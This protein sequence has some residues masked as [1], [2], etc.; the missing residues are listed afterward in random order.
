MNNQ[1]IQFNKGDVTQ[2]HRIIINDD[3]TECENN[4]NEKFLSNIALDRDI[5]E[6]YITVPQAIVTIDDTLEGDCCEFRW[7]LKTSYV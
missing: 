5:P 2:T 1:T 4:P 3:N 6:I 7:S